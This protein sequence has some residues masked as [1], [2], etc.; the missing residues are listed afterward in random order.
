MIPCSHGIILYREWTLIYRGETAGTNPAMELR[1]LNGLLN[2]P[3]AC[4]LCHE[5]E[6]CILPH[7]V[8]NPSIHMAC[9]LWTVW[10]CHHVLALLIP[11]CSVSIG[12]HAWKRVTAKSTD[13]PFGG[14]GLLQAATGN[15]CTLLPSAS[16][17][18]EEQAIC[19][20]TYVQ[21]AFAEQG[22]HVTS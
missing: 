2:Q 6:T 3:D 22:N 7:H 8:Q 11:M 4:R 13:A 16:G 20:N 21:T 1:V 18:S 12:F 19:R 9:L 17:D 15:I 5:K 14:T 10:G